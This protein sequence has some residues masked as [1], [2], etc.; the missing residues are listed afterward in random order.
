MLMEKM[1]IQ[2]LLQ[3]YYDGSTSRQDELDLIEYFSVNEA[4]KE[5]KWAKEQLLG[6][7]DI[8]KEDIPVPEN[9]QQSILHR[10]ESVQ[11]KSTSRKLNTRPLY[12]AISVAASVVMIISALIFLNH[13]PDLGSIEDTELAYAE[14]KEALDLVSKYFNQGTEHLHNLNKIEEA[15]KPLDNLQRVDDTRKALGYLKSLNE[16][17][18]TV[19]GVLNFNE[20]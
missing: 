15:V 6:L 4:P 5:W 14:T 10:L 12:S 7:Q 2:L 13:Q 18:E 8:S 9:L 11:N 16:G 1:R 20:Q 19:K 17:V 3:K